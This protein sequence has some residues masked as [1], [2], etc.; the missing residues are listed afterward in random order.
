[1][2]LTTQK[3][4]NKMKKK[5]K[6]IFEKMGVWK[7]IRSFRYPRLMVRNS[8]YRTTKSKSEPPI[9]PQHLMKLVIDPPEAAWYL[10]SGKFAFKD[11]QRTLNKNGISPNQFE[12]VLDFGCGTGRI[13]WRWAN[14]YRS[15]IY[16]SD[17]NKSLVNYC[18]KKFK[19]E[20]ICKNGLGPPLKFKKEEFSFIYANSVFTHLNKNLQKEWIKEMKRVLKENGLLYITLH[21]NNSVHLMDEK[22]KEEYSKGNIVVKRPD[23]V[24][25]NVCAAFHPQSY[26]EGEF[27]IGFELVNHIPN[28]TRHAV[29]DIYLFRKR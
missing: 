15:Q 29:Q 8:V 26:V 24:G 17:Y 13:M 23:R 3:I 28:G 21:G 27:S 14:N 22:E 4:N 19:K 9:P 20:I 25:T 7:N 16:G 10:R 2:K 5:L 12:K 11:I 18:K 6:P 1:M